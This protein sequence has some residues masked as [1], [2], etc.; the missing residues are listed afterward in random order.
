MCYITWSCSR[1][2]DVG[3]ITSALKDQDLSFSSVNIPH[4][5]HFGIDYRYFSFSSL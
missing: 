4:L 5:G 2:K 1:F 3:V